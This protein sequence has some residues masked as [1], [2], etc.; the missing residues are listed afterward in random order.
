MESMVCTSFNLVPESVEQLELGTPEVRS[1]WYRAQSSFAPDLGRFPVS[2][3]GVAGS[4]S[5]LVENSLS[6]SQLLGQPVISSLFSCAAA[7]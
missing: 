1:Q 5:V 2:L 4:P 7:G 3:P 6:V